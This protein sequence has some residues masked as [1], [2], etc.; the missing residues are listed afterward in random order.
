MIPIWFFT[1]DFSR[2]TLILIFTGSILIGLIM[3]WVGQLF[4][5][6]D[7]GFYERME[8][9]RGLKELLVLSKDLFTEKV[10]VIFILAF[11]CISAATGAYFTGS[12]YYMDNVLEVSG[13]KA[14]LPDIING[15]AQMAFFPVVIWLVVINRKAQSL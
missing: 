7:E 5:K 10:F 3:I 15:I 14:T 8:V 11:F 12:I 4:V 2:T 1:G 13:L 6:E 9:T